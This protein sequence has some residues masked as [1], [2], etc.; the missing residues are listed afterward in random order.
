MVEIVDFFDQMAQT[1]VM[2]AVRDMVSKVAHDLR[3]D[4][5]NVARRNAQ[6]ISLQVPELHAARLEEILLISCRA[7]TIVVLDAL[8]AGVPP[9]SVELSAEALGHIRTLVVYGIALDVVSRA[10]RVG[11]YDTME[12]WSKAVTD[13]FATDAK[14][15]P[16]AT[17][18]TR[19]VLT[20]MDR[21]LAQMAHEFKAEDERITRERA[22]RQLADVRLLLSSDPANLTSIEARLGYRLAGKHQAVVLRRTGVAVDLAHAA[23]AL[24]TGPTPLQIPFDDSTLWCWGSGPVRDAEVPGV[25]VG[26]GRVRRGLDGFRASHAE[27]TEAL[28]V[29]ELNPAGA[30]A[31]IENVAVTALCVVDPHRALEFVTAALGPLMATTDAAQRQR[32]TLQAFL[33]VGGNSRQAGTRLGLHHNTVRYR[34]TQ[35]EELLE[36]PISPQRLELEL[37][38]RLFDDLGIATHAPHA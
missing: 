25:W 7:N 8:I 15:V 38:L 22:L 35:I 17:Y 27:A 10:Y 16:T 26:V 31:L 12:R 1:G 28:R 11:A 33:E 5:D 20:W 23:R 4:I 37:A 32:D 2:T 21:V 34:L 6:A 9:E 29:A 24:F 19:F 3:D 18:G 30:V 14:A 13:R 36:R